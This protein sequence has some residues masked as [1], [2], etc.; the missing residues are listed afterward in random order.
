MHSLE[1]IMSLRWSHDTEIHHN[2]DVRCALGDE[3]PAAGLIVY[4]LCKNTVIRKGS[5]V[6]GR[7]RMK[8]KERK[9]GTNEEKTPDA[10]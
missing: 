2:R 1:H 8:E 5:M 7:H 3:L 4:S 10:V 6:Q 9:I